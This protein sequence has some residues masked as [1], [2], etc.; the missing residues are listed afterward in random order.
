MPHKHNADRRHRI[1]K[2]KFKV[3]NWAEYE[4]GLC[5]RCSLTVWVTP[6]ALLGWAAP[7]RKTRGGQPRYSDLAIETTLM[8]GMVFGLR[9]RQSEG[10]LRSVLDMMGLD[11][12]VPDHTTLSRRARTWKPSG[13]SNDRQHVAGGSIHVLVDSTGLKIYGAGQWLEEKHGAKSRRGW[14]KLHLAVDADSGEVIAHSL[15][16][17]ETGDASQ[18]EPLLDQINEEIGQFT[19]DGAYDGYP[20]YDAVLRHSA[21]AKV[22]IPPRSNAV[23]RPSAQ[24]CC[25]R[26]DHIASM[27]IDGRLKWQTSTG[28]GK[29]ALAETAM[30]RYKGVIGPRL[31]ARSF[32]AQQTE[33]AIGVT[34]LNRM[35]ACGRP[36]SVRCEVSA[37]ATK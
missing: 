20:T 35:L 11:L 21:G 2:M 17:Q 15:T 29:R 9:L 7:R 36:K 27:Q 18:L 16:D 14:R 10:L 4:A 30:G 23:E 37:E 8:L 24:S 25:Q 28:Y 32:L 1:G 31:R 5:R 33:A 12:S 3:M 34:I 22:V 19:A 26:D 6:E 13:R